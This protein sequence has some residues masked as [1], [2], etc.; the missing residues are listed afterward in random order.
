[1]TNGPG[2]ATPM[3]L[4]CASSF[5][6]E[7][8]SVVRIPLFCC[9]LAANLAYADDK[10]APPLAPKPSESAPIESVVLHPL[11]ATDYACSEHFEGQLP[12][13]GDAL[14]SDCIVQGGLETGFMKAYRGNGEKNEDWYGWGE[15]VLA[16]VDGK[17]ERI[18]VNPVVNQPGKLGKPPA[19]FIMLRRDDGT[20]V[21]VAHVADIKVAVGDRVR[22]GQPLGVVGNNGF[23]RAPHIHIGAWRDKMPLQIR[24][25]L[26]ATAALR[27]EP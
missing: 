16:P 10:V 1:M 15:A 19:S 23:A 20:Y 4:A 11:F 24:F 3:A 2:S 22:A 5:S 7:D 8:A 13:L 9:L 17:V 18:N 27:K 12:Y 6:T 21:M 26:R 25:D 14:G